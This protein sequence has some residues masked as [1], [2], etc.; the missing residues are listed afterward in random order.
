MKVSTLSPFELVWLLRQNP[1]HSS[2]GSNWQTPTRILATIRMRGF[3]DSVVVEVSYPIQI[4]HTGWMC[5]FKT[6]ASPE[7]FN[8]CCELQVLKRHSA[9][10][11]SMRNLAQN[12]L[13]LIT[14]SLICEV[15]LRGISVKSPV[16]LCRGHTKRWQAVGTTVFYVKKVNTVTRIRMRSLATYWV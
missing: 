16:T 9:M 14:N 1:S 15:H 11:D 2:S 10:W 6:A 7:R 13:I 5:W 12:I 4:S 3:V 8:L